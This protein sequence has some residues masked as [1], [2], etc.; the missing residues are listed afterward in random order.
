MTEIEKFVS[1]APD[2]WVRKYGAS[3]AQDYDT[4]YTS[5]Y[6][7]HG[8]GKG[9]GSWYENDNTGKSTQTTTQTRDYDAS[10]REAWEDYCSESEHSIVS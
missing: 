6:Q 2:Y 9:K 10:W 8:H 3:N 5:T 7:R 4:G 1:A